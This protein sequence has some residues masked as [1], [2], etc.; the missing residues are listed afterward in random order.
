MDKQIFALKE[1]VYNQGLNILLQRMEVLIDSYILKELCSPVIISAEIVDID[2]VIEKIKEKWIIFNIK[3]IEIN[4]KSQRVEFKIWG[5]PYWINKK[6]SSYMIFDGE[7]S[8]LE[9]EEFNYQRITKEEYAEKNSL[10][11]TSFI[12]HGIEIKVI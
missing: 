3:D 12:G 2:A 8:E 5:G 4:L 9:T 11:L 1:L 7:W 6:N 10:S